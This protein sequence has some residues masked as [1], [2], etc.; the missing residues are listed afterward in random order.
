MST[1][2]K[3][4]VLIIGCGNIAGGFDMHKHKNKPPCTHMG[5][6][7]NDER[8]NVLVCIDSDLNKAKIF[9]D[10]WHI[11][12]YFST[13]DDVINA[14]FIIDIISICSPTTLHEPQSLAALALK[15][16]LLFCEKPLAT[17]VNKAKKLIE[18]CEQQDVQLAVNYTRRWDPDIIDLKK[19]IAE[20][21]YGELRSIIACYNKGILN[22]GSHLIDVLD[23]L[24]GKLT[25]VATGKHCID[26]AKNDPSIPVMLQS[27]SGTPIQFNIGHAADFSLFEIEFVF[28]NCS[29][30]MLNGG[31]YWSTR[32]IESDSRFSGYQTLAKPIE[33]KGR[34]EQAMTT[35][36]NNIFQ[37]LQNKKLLLSNAENAFY[38]QE[39]CEKILKTKPN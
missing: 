29:I 14:G 15:P 5:A 17:S 24:I 30:K 13:I 23:Y 7:A 21:S 4:N 31:L 20:K 3:L 32:H 10:Y 18:Q 2:T 37:S 1:S 19:A 27:D 36:V 33:R 28:S 6:Y 34:Y 35:A 16:K 25:I 26:Y 9:A 11:P 38:T 39:L 22:I 12:N 8:F